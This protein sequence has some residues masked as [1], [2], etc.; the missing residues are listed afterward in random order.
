MSK[1]ELALMIHPG[2]RL[3]SSEPSPAPLQHP[4]KVF[5]EFS[6]DTGNIVITLATCGHPMPCNVIGL[7]VDKS[8]DYQ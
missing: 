7:D 4:P 3:Q 8:H 6:M 2:H 5:P 1:E